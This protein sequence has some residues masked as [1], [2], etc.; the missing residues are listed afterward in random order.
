MSEK[1]TRKEANDI[2]RN[3]CLKADQQ[4]KVDIHKAH[5]IKEDALTEA[6]KKRMKTKTKP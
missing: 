5:Q 2:Y 3:D 4:Y 1:I 6:A